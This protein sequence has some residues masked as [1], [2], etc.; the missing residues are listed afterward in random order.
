[1]LFRS[2]PWKKTSESP[3]NNLHLAI[4]AQ[5]NLRDIKTYITEDLENPQA[6]LAIV[7][8]ITKS[9]R[10]LREHAYIG[11]PLSSIADNKEDYR[12]LVSGSYMVFYRVNGQDVYVDRVLYGR[13]DYL[14]VLFRELPEETATE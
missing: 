4:E 5:N 6:A 8:R 3:M 2:R 9:I 11:A 7:R 14:S 13:R 1:M 10:M 12:F